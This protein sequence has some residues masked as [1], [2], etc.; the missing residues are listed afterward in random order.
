MPCLAHLGEVARAF[1]RLTAAGVS[2][3][4]V[5]QADPIRLASWVSTTPLPFP[6]VSDPDRV[7]Y[8]TFALRRVGWG[9]FFRP[10]VIGEYLRLMIRGQ[11]LRKP[12]PGEDVLQLGGDF[13]LDRSRR[14]IVSRPSRVATDRP[15]VEEILTAVRRAKP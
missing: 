11:Q 2:V 1:D 10:G 7:A 4:A 13:V 14:L 3:L 12:L 5:A 9:H 8:R 15:T 6:L